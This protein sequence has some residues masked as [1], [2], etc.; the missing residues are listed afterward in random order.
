MAIKIY[1]KEMCDVFIS[2][3]IE[4]VFVNIMFLFQMSM[5]YNI[6]KVY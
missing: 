1:N 6:Y 4:K 3:Y 2:S 5:K